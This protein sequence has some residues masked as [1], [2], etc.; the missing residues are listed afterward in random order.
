MKV[1][2]EDAM[3]VNICPIIIYFAG[4]RFIIYYD[5]VTLKNPIQSPGVAFVNCYMCATEDD[6]FWGRKVF[7]DM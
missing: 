2:R 3:E 5:E 7:G 1:G 4:D 6:Q